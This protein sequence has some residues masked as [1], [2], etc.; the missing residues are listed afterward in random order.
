MNKP[1]EELTAKQRCNLRYYLKK[2]NDP[3]F[4]QKQ[5]ESS[6]KYYNSRK[7]DVEF[8]GKLNEDKKKN[9]HKKKHLSA[10]QFL[11]NIE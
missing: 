6:A 10:E 11:P 9:Y 7:T 3:D 1:I 8:L 4:M 2:K 5:R